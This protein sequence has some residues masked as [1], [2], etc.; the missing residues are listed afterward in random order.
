M[1]SFINSQNRK[2]SSEIV[3]KILHKVKNTSFLLAASTFPALLNFVMGLKT[4]TS[5]FLLG[6][7]IELFGN[8]SFRTT[9][10]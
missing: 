7:I 8:L 5:G 4:S 3:R 10:A 6:K 2:F 9:S 1:G